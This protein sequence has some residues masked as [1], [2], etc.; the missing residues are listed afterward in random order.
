MQRTRQEPYTMQR[1]RQE[2]CTMQRTRQEPYT[3]QR[4]RQA[5]L[6]R[7]YSI[8]STAGVLQ[9]LRRQALACVC[10]PR[11][12]WATVCL[13]W[14]YWQRPQRAVQPDARDGAAG[15]R[16]ALSAPLAPVPHC[17]RQDLVERRQTSTW[18]SM[19]HNPSRGAVL[20]VATALPVT[21]G[22]QRTAGTWHY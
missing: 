8:L 13:S 12:V 18:H 7:C 22:I 5:A 15:H 9:L 10:M 14:V 3:M 2:P 19:Q 4:T 16:H 20:E 1:T 11:R 6:P 17:R 21:R